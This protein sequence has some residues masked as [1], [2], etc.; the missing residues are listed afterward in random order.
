[1]S[2]QSPLPSFSTASEVEL[3]FAWNAAL[4]E[5]VQLA[6]GLRLVW[7]RAPTGALN[8]L[9]ACRIGE[10]TVLWAPAFGAESATCVVGLGAARIVRAGGAQR[11]AD[12]RR[13]IERAFGERVHH[14]KAP[15]KGPR[16]QWPRFWGGMSFV[17]GHDARGCWESFGEATFVLPRWSY[18]DEGDGGWLG[19]VYD[20]EKEAPDALFAECRQLWRAMTEPAPPRTPP[21]TV[22]VERREST[23]AAEWAALIDSIHAG[24]RSGSLHKVVAA[25]RSTLRLSPAPDP[26]GV[27]QQLG[28]L[29]PGCSRFALRIGERTFLGATPERLVSRRG[30]RIDTDAIAGSAAADVEHAAER[31][32]ASAKDRAEHE[33]VV[34]AI[35][36]VL[37]PL[38]AELEVPAEPTVRRLRHVLHLQTPIRGVLA[39]DVHL[40]DLADR[41]HPTPAVGGVPTERAL[42]WIARSERTER[43]WYAS[44]IGWVDPNGDGELLV[45]LRSALILED[46]VHLYAGAGI[47]AGSEAS[48]EYAETEMKLAGMRT[49]L[50]VQAPAVPS[51]GDPPS[52]GRAP[53]IGGSHGAP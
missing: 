6:S 44:P 27:F 2:A 49:A 41:L 46:R 48:S 13:G 30:R 18:V 42:D 53:H 4:E 16:G 31:L 11:L 24:I 20:P 38:C 21:T 3:T 34:A 36:D 32:L 50:G 33:Y 9:A 5:A 23:S 17:P 45:A 52:E 37:S 14:R 1:M 15:A 12:A 7:M 10:H 29:A 51:S 28:E 26:A 43:G 39:G 8:R 35:R 22:A 19:A 25:R 40:L 47:V